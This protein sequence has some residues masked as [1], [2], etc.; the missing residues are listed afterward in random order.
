MDIAIHINPSQPHQIEHGEWWRKGLKRHGLDLLITDKINKKA[1]VH[2]VSGNHYAKY[3]WIGHPR[4]IWLDKRFYKEGPKSDGMASDPYV[5]L[6]WMNEKGGRD[7]KEGT[8]KQAP[9]I[10]PL[11]MGDRSI[12]LAEYGG[13]IEEAD[14]IRLHPMAETPRETLLEALSRHD[15]AIGYTSTALVAAALEG[16]R[17]DCRD[18]DGF[19]SQ[20]N[21]LELLP[22]V[23]WHYT[24]IESGEAWEHLCH[25]LSP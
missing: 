15:I 2:I 8:G 18:P 11:K 16:L 20:P 19:M 5:S 24:E 7:F 22:Y 3:A 6:G 21:W 4:T 17:V 1:D 10:K 14:T 23:D 13:I 25:S 9:K 12:F